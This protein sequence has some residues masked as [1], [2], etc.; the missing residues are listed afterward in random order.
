MHAVSQVAALAPIADFVQFEERM[1]LAEPQ[2]AR[3]IGI[4]MARLEGGASSPLQ[5]RAP[6]C[7]AFSWGGGLPSQAQWTWSPLPP[8]A[9]VRLALAFDATLVRANMCPRVL[10]VPGS[11]HGTGRIAARK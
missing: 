10:T 4:R 8:N 9:H 3:T 2:W 11:G 6:C 5:S 1:C 7:W